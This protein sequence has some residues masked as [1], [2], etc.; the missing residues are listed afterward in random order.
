[1]NARRRRKTARLV[2]LDRNN[3]IFLFRHQDLS[4]TYWVTPGGGVEPG[5]SWEEAARRELWEETGVEN[6]P[7]GPWLWRREKDG[8]IS[9]EPVR[10]VERYYLVKAEPDAIHT[11]NQLEYEQ[12]VYSMYH[13][14]TVD[15]LRATT[16]TVYPEGLV[17]F[18][19]RLLIEG[20]P[21]EPIELPEAW[22]DQASV[23]SGP[24]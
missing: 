20:A 3:R 6:V 15:E 11:A 9:G 8:T 12:V 18:L 5:E 13:W 2:L 1:M 4:D 21:S 24:V 19:D 23:A 10:N 16:Q 22:M 17:D 7:L 14:W